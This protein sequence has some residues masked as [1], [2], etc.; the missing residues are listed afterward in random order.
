MRKEDFTKVVDECDL[1]S[2]QTMC[3]AIETRT[4]FIIAN[5]T[6]W[7]MI[8]AGD[9]KYPYDYT[10]NLIRWG[11]ASKARGTDYHARLHPYCPNQGISTTLSCFYNKAVE[12]EYY[13]PES[14]ERL[15]GGAEF[16]TIWM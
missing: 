8:V 15:N 3:K 12:L 5:N 13:K 16:N 14:T 1:M 10:W 7:K 2:I 9:N 6:R 4:C 11:F